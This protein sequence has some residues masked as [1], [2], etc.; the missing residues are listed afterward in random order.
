MKKALITCAIVGGL[1]ASYPAL[2]TDQAA[3]TNRP[4]KAVI[5]MPSR[6]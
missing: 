3:S 1:L 2:S 6:S 5:I 4:A